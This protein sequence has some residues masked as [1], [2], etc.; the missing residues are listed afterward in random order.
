MQVEFYIALYTGDSNK[1]EVVLNKIETER[2][3]WTMPELENWYGNF[4]GA[5]AQPFISTLDRE[6]FMEPVNRNKSDKKLKKVQV[7]KI[8]G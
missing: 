4:G 1:M 7:S 3:T 5:K 8:I 6:I 2:K